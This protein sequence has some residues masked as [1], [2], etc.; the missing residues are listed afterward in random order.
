MIF[1]PLMVELNWRFISINWNDIAKNTSCSEQWSAACR[2]SQLSPQGKLHKAV[3]C[4]VKLSII[5][6]PIFEKDTESLGLMKRCGA[7]HYP[8]LPIE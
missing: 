6:I 4:Y 1:L 7:D 5:M 8:L 2:H 3:S